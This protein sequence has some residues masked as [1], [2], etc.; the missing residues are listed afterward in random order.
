MGWEERSFL[1]C[2]VSVIAATVSE[3]TPKGKLG[4]STSY[5][6]SYK[7]EEQAKGKRHWEIP[8]R[9]REKLWKKEDAKEG[10][11]GRGQ[12][13]KRCV[14]GSLRFLFFACVDMC[15]RFDRDEQS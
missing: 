11:R 12:G 5:L 1:R 7:K 14:Q 2:E 13:N 6:E 9:K 15:R 3:T 10:E 4:N 8:T